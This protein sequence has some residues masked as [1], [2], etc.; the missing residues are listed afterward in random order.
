MVLEDC[1]L[2]FECSKKWIDLKD[3]GHDKVRFC[4][5]CKKPVV[6]CITQEELDKYLNRGDC[7]CYDAIR[8]CQPI[9]LSGHRVPK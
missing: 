3:L 6:L 4:E 5:Q 2:T 9:R 8:L 1:Q 7:V